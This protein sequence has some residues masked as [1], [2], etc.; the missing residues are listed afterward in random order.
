MDNSKIS[1]KI[2]KQL[3]KDKKKL[4]NQ[5]TALKSQLQS[6]TQVSQVILDS[7]DRLTGLKEALE[8]MP[9]IITKTLGGKNAKSKQS[10][11]Q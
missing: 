5:V 1:K 10:K 7:K 2:I 11:R 9:Q 8:R 4:S 3:I 6:R